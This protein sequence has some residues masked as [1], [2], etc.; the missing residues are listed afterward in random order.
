MKTISPDINVHW[1]YLTLDDPD[2][3]S[4]RCLY[5]YVSPNKNEILYIGKSW[6]VSV[7]A[8]WGRTAK[9]SFWNDLERKRRI[10]NHFAL[11]GT[12][13]LTYKGR[14]TSELLSD[15]ESLLIRGEQPWGNIQCKQ[16]RIPRPG[17]V[18]ECAG[19]WPGQAR[20]YKD[21]A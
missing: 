5:A 7:K 11:L 1:R 2:W 16:S 14:L 6:G 17:L 10:K 20:F 19:S 21:N 8:R 15:I 3:A 12:I 9:K 4:M 18:V 13:S